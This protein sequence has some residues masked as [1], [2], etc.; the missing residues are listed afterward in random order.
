[1]PEEIHSEIQ[2]EIQLKQSTR[3]WNEEANLEQWE[4]FYYEDSYDGYRLRSREKKLLEFLDSLSLPK[5]SKILELGYGAGVTSAKVYSRGFNLIGIDIS[6]KLRRLAIQNCRKV[7]N[8]AEGR[9]AGDKK[10][11][12]EAKFEFRI[13]NAEKLDFPDG[14]FD[15]VIGLGFLH[16]LQYPLSCVKDVFRVLK[17]GGHFVVTQRNMFGLGSNDDPVKWLRSL[18]YL[19]SRRRYELRWRDTFLI[20]PL[21]AFTSLFSLRKLRQQLIEHKRMGLVRK[22]A[23]SFRRMKRLLEKGGFTIIRE[24]GA[25]YMSKKRKYFP[26]SAK[27]LDRYLQGISDRREKSWIH[28]I[29]NGTV[30][31]ARKS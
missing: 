17:P 18:Y 15:C 25:G 19:F 31:L 4:T 24:G 9:K 23:F 11:A 29:G 8:K 10:A 13:G 1:M 6:D 28:R 16:Y 12:N 20:H 7:R 30:F 5:G 3:K 21:L 14:N 27:R 2:P 22:N 26:E